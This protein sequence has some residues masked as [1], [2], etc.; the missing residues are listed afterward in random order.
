M[1]MLNNQRVSSLID[2]FFGTTN[3]LEL[4]PGDPIVKPAQGP[5][6]LESHDSE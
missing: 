1:A 2:P 4:V 3:Y 6:R 5:P